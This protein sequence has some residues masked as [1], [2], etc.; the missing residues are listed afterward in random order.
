M[1]EPVERLQAVLLAQ[2]EQVK[3]LERENRQLSTLKD[4]LEKKIHNLEH[5]Q[6]VDS[7]MIIEMPDGIV[8]IPEDIH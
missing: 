6:N 4:T 7:S 1:N 3:E 8:L 5:S 2:R